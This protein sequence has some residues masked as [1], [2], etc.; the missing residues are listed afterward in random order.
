MYSQ[1]DFNSAVSRKV[2]GSY[3]DATFLAVGNDAVREVLMDID[4]RSMIRKTALGPN[5]LRNIY[6]YTC[7]S[8][9]KGDR[10]IDIEP[11][12]NR[13]KNDFWRLTDPEEFDRSKELYQENLVAIET[14]DLIRK[15]LL[16]KSVDDDTITIGEL[17]SVGDWAG[18]G[19]GENL[20]LDNSNFVNGVGAINWDINANGGTTAGI[21]NSSLDTFDISDYLT[22]GSIFV[23]AYIPNTADITNFTLRVGTDASNYYSIT[24]TTTNEGNAFENGWNLLRF[25][26]V[27]KVETGTVTNDSCS[28]GAIYMTKDASKTYETDYRFDY[29]VMEKG[30][31]YDIWYYSKYGWQSSAGVYEQDAT[32]ITDNLNVDTDEFAIIVEKGAELMEEDLK[33]YGEADRHRN[34]Y[35]LLKKRYIDENPSRAMSMIQTYYTL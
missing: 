6:T 24:V 5:L 35:E 26:L 2:S 20:T 25:D 14:H 12:I 17:D 29:I 34:K 19:D 7:P 33:N 32:D 13:G 8:D 15:I 18:F 4:M 27:N 10:I 30:E 23:W 11:Q 3:D 9:M 16:S 21:V 28:Y 31:H 22:E 1:A